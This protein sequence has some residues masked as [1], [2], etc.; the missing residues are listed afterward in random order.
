VAE[1][2]NPHAARGVRI[3]LVKR[4]SLVLATIAAFFL[5]GAREGRGQS[6]SGIHLG[7][8]G[9]A[10]LPIGDTF[11]TWR[12]GYQ[13]SAMLEYDLPASPVTVRLEGGYAASDSSSTPPR[14]GSATRRIVSG[15]ANIII[16]ALGTAVRPYI[17]AG[18]GIYRLRISADAYDPFGNIP[19][20]RIEIGQ[21]VFGLN[22]G[23]G[24]S[25]SIAK[26]LKGFVEGRYTYLSTSP[27]Y[28][29]VESGSGFFQ[30]MAGVAF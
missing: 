8:A 30:L 7:L 2:R 19:P 3:P 11:P 12:T 14:I 29:L 15:S 6:A 20:Y 18:G 28:P 21:T 26:R 27:A 13:F 1:A 9:G 23:A 5:F 4:T 22:A 24:L 16:G 25:F 10:T 17:L